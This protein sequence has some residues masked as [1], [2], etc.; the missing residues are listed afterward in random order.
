MV[1]VPSILRTEAS[2]RARPV[3]A[4]LSRRSLLPHYVARTPSLIWA[5]GMHIIAAEHHDLLTS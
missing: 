3:A 4:I 2:S 1:A 5:F